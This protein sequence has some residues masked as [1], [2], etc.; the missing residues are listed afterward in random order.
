MR[1]EGDHKGPDLTGE[2]GS[3]L[4][5]IDSRSAAVSADRASL[6]ARGVVTVAGGRRRESLEEQVPS[7]SVLV[8]PVVPPSREGPKRRRPSSR[9]VSIFETSGSGATEGR[10]LLF[11]LP[12]SR[13]I[14]P[15]QTYELR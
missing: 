2:V 9:E 15:P 8:L 10:H 4:K 3:E 5:E 1:L 11:P 13:P 12:G 7:R 6:V 14:S